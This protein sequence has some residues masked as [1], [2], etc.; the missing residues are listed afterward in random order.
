MLAD[1]RIETCRICGKLVQSKDMFKGNQM[2]SML[3]VILLLLF[4]ST[5]VWVSAQ[6]ENPY[7]DIPMSRTEDGGFVLGDPDAPVRMIEFADFICPSCQS[8]KE[9]INLFIEQYVITGQAAFEYRMLPITDPQLSQYTADL[10]ECADIESEGSFWQAY[11]VMYNIASGEQMSPESITA[12]ASTLGLDEEALNSCTD[13]ANQYEADMEYARSLNVTSTPTILMQYGDNNPVQIA[14]PGTNQFELLINAVR[15]TSADPITIE[16]GRYTGIQTYRTADGGIVMGDPDAPL[17]LVAFEDFMCPHCQSYQP[18]VHS[19]IADYVATGQAKFEYR[20]FPLV[21]PE[22]SMLTA[23]LAECIA[24]QDLSAF[25]NAHDLIFEFA[26]SQEIDDQITSIVPMLVEVDPDAIETCMDNSLQPMIDIGL[27]QN[28]GVS[29]TPGIRARDENGTLDVIYAGQQPLTSGALP[30]EAL[31]ALAEGSEELSIG[32][33]E[34]TL[35]DSSLLEDDSIITGEPCSA[36]CWQN[37]TPGETSLADARTTIEQ[38]ANT[39]I[40]DGQNGFAFALDSAIVCCQIS[41]QDATTVSTILVQVAPTST[42]GALIEAQG[43]P[44]FVSGEPFTDEEHIITLFYPDLNALIYTVVAGENG[45]LSD[46]TPIFTLIY[47]SDQIMEQIVNNSPLDN[48]K[49]YLTYSDYMDGEF[50]YNG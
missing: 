37:I 12:F 38:L 33:P 30:L 9:T 25:W 41:S 28:V 29:G 16:T 7:A 8:Y 20:F 34:Q 19:F 13:T 49:G 14:L 26:A 48:W 45:Q 2:N 4:I 27:G 18:T 11:D 21:S 24:L 31:A 5:T 3:K 42:L 46:D 36:P 32:Q 44:A 47:T 43:D 50:D 15:P 39:S 17:T 6:E 10:V 40:Q 22:F 1:T 23:Q 35:L